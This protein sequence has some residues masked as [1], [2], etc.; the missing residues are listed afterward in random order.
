MYE[1]KGDRFFD[2]GVGFCISRIDD[3]GTEH[4]HTHDFIEIV[5]M[6]SGRRT[7]YIDGKA[8]Q[9]KSGDVLFINYG[10][11]H[12]YDAG[13]NAI[14]Y[15]LL[16][17]PEFLDGS[18]KECRDAMRLLDHD[19]FE[20]FKARLG[21]EDCVCSFKG[22]ALRSARS[23]MCALEDEY[24]NADKRVG[25]EELMRAYMTAFLILLFREVSIIKEARAK[26]RAIGKEV[27]EYIRTHSAQ[28][29]ELTHLADM[30]HYN[31]S[32][33]S[34]AFRAHTGVSLSEYVKAIRLEN[35]CALL[36]SDRD[37]SVE[38]IAREVGFSDKSAFFREFRARMGLS[39]GEYRKCKDQTLDANA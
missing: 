30:C 22:S 2:R 33:F 34:R 5:Y 31:R 15:N 20:K 27:F 16:L 29:I 38:E 10:R 11:T 4:T 17:V 9:T 6:I 25:S 3:N 12:S 19:S 36:M 7:H 14:M 37:K 23:I 26:P 13:D 21:R 39:P 28:R 24:K 8:V 18:F 35:A 1:Y 32:Y